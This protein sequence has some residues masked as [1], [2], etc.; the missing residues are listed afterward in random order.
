MKL[1]ALQFGTLFI[2]L[3]V[4]PDTARAAYC[5]LTPS[6]S[7]TST[8]YQ[9]GG[10]C[11]SPAEKGGCYLNSGEKVCF[12][13]CG[14]CGAFYNM[15]YQN[16]Q[17]GYAELIA[18]GY[19]MASNIATCVP[20]KECPAGY[21]GYIDEVSQE[22]NCAL[23]PSGATSQ[24]GAGEISDCFCDSGYYGIINSESDSC[25]RCPELSA[26][27]YGTSPAAST[28]VTECYVPSNT[29]Y[30]DSSGKYMYTQNCFYTN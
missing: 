9:M 18:S 29:I 14:S 15:E 7:G 2:A 12:M 27:Q 16:V 5:T 20:K 6:C 22:P 21:Y 30:S 13:E 10:H 8:S 17:I 3:A 4:A 1:T 26:G 24:I 19:D 11:A 28:S 23:C 25:T